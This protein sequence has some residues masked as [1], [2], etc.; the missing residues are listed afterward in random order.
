MKNSFMNFGIYFELLLVAWLA[1]CPP[2]N[3]ALGTANVRLVHWFPAIPWA[4]LIVLY[5]EI[6]K[7]LMR[8]TSP[9]KTDPNTGRQARE[10]GWLERFTYY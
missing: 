2:I 8:S 6:R 1:Y 3:T 4:I 10:A 5:D 7:A 9:S